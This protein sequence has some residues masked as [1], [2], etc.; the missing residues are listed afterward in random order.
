MQAM[1]QYKGKTTFII[2]TD[3][4]RGYGKAWT[5]HDHDVDG[6]ENIWIALIGPGIAPLGE[7]RNA[8]KVTQAQIAATLAW[9]VGED[10][11]GAVEG[12]GKPISPK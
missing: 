12:V 6:A 11:A 5:D 10:Y 2:S 3:H 8:P 9:A 7:R 4:G 1:P